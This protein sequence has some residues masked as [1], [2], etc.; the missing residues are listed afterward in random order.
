MAMPNG[1]DNNIAWN[2]GHLI[3]V[4]QLLCYQLSGVPMHISKDQVRMYK[5]GTSPAD[6]TES[7]NIPQLQTQLIE[8]PKL[9]AE[10]LA[11]NKFKKYRQYTTSTGITLTSL[12]DAVAFNHFHEGLHA[13]FILA[14]RNF[15]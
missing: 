4:Q 14:I 8:M 1:F 2:V 5:T 10:D 9:F 12:D 7:P 15:L 11:A 3:V 6:W 13:G